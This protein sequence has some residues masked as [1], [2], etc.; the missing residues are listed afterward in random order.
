MAGK[1]I[2]VVEDERVVARDIEKRLKKLGYAIAASVSTGQDAIVAAAEHHPDL[3]LMDIRLKGDMDGVEAAEQIR[4]QQDIPIIYLTAYADETTLQRA[5]ITEPFGYIIKPFDEKDLHVAIEVALRRR[6]AELAV[7]VAL[8]KEKELSELKSRFWSM[9]AHEFRNPM[10]VILSYAQILETHGHEL[11]DSQKQEY[12]RTIQRDIRA[13][14][15]LLS[16]VLA[17]SR[18]EGDHL[19]FKPEVIDLALFC[20]DLVQEMQFSWGRSH[21]IIFNA[22]NECDNPCF[23]ANL[24][25]HILSNLLANAMKYSPDGSTI[26]FNLTYHDEVAIIQIRDFGI[27][28]PLEAQESM[29]DPF[30]RADNVGD[31]SGTGLGL[32]MVKKCL[33][34][35]GG[36]ISVSSQLA[37]GTTFTVSIAASDRCSLVNSQSKNFPS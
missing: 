12:L 5:K 25:W 19:S 27:G 6:L 13:M 10:S 33:D 24:L 3:I 21:Q 7:Q 32:T 34:L 36:S 9:V 28:I 2:L 11:P 37:V 4:S 17:I 18:V 29:F 14:D 16:D 15:R 31:I 26:Y 23:D 30:Y 8:E 1:K 35:H 22:Q 20:Q